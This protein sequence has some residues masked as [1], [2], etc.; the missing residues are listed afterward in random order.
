MLNGSITTEA[1]GL[2]HDD[3]VKASLSRGADEEYHLILN[4]VVRGYTGTDILFV[5]SSAQSGY[6]SKR[7]TAVGRFSSVAKAKEILIADITRQSP[8]S[9]CKKVIR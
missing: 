4:L 3:L 5:Y 1:S 8:R 2:I 7:F 9:C 6:G